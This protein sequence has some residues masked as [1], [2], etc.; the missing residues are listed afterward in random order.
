M[1]VRVVE[2]D[3]EYVIGS[4]GISFDTLCIEYLTQNR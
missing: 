2:F 3:L 4:E 1:A